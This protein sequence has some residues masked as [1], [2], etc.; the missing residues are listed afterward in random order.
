M[1]A[2]LSLCVGPVIHWRLVQ[3]VPR[4]R[5]KAPAIPVTLSAVCGVK[6]NRWMEELSSKLGGIE[7]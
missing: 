5:P 6:D 7:Y 2:C 4:P 3:G 1:K